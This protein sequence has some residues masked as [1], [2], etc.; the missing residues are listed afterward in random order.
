MKVE[1]QEPRVKSR[2]SWT[3]SVRSFKTRRSSRRGLTLIELLVV[4]IILTTI[5][6]AAIPIMAPSN[7]D[8]RLREAARNVNTFLVGAQS[9]AISSNRPY[10]VALKRLAADTGQAEDNGVC[11]ELFYVEQQPPYAGFDR[12]SRACVAL[13]PNQLGLS[14]VRLVTN[15]SPTGFML[16]VGLVPD[17][18][19]VAMFRPGDVIEIHGTR[20]ELLDP[21]LI[22]GGDNWANVNV[23]EKTGFFLPPSNPR[24]APTLFARPVNDSGQQIQPEYESRGRA[25][26][27]RPVNPQP[28][29]PFWTAPAPYKILRQP[30]LA[31]DE[32]Y[33]L[34][35]GTAIDLRASGL[36]STRFFYN[37]DARDPNSRVDNSQNVIIM[38]APEGGISRL[39]FNEKPAD[40]ATD[41]MFDSPVAE[42]LYLLVGK[43]ENIPAPPLNTDPSLQSSTLAA[44]A[45]DEQRSE[46]R[47]PINWLNG[48]SRWVV[49]GPQS[50]RIVT[51]EN[52]FVDFSTMLTTLA[53]PPTGDDRNT[54]IA[55][56]REFTREMA[57]LGGR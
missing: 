13:A 47:E 55:A 17:L 3:T 31:S 22:P 37:P 28:Q 34:P 1:S 6:A 11:L 51:I 8:R 35:E 9:R 40:N 10:G 23:D 30:T 43:R 49:V 56:A 27:D 50:G 2:S 48:T 57:Q 7:D 38:F 29:R 41:E 45:T 21:K 33:Q 36:G 46:L 15:G 44:T 26:R 19:P 16:P 54:Q 53:T 18:F 20:F 24:S 25:L 4:I 52:G 39:S 5:V 32:P 14:L 42:N 12:N